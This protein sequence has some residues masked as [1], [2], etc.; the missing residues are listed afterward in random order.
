MKFGWR[1]AFSP[2]NT[3]FGWGNMII[4]RGI[5]W[6]SFNP[7]PVACNTMY[8]RPMSTSINQ[9][10][11]S[12]KVTIHR[13]RCTFNLHLH[14]ST[15]MYLRPRSTS[16]GRDVPSTEVSIHRPRCTFDQGRHPSTGLYLVRWTAGK[17]LSSGPR[18]QSEA[19]RII[20]N[21]VEGPLK[22]KWW[23][24]APQP[25]STHPWPIKNRVKMKRAKWKWNDVCL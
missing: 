13:P 20:K 5:I 1:K 16:I 24:Y 9:D 21:W 19:L 7:G 22:L 10:V 17:K 11:L 25:K 12:T 6:T 3:I 14:P 4:G 2:G 18:R 8:V 15:K 23:V